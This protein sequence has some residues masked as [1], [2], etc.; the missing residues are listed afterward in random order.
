[1][2]SAIYFPTHQS[3]FGEMI[4]TGHLSPVAR[5]RIRPTFN[6]TRPGADDDDPVEYH[7]A[8]LAHKFAKI[9]G[10]SFPLF[11]DFPRYAPD[12]KVRD[13]TSSG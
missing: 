12:Y 2:H 5:T 7:L 11:F 1:M 3:K 4:G 13:G 8:D 10:T 9:W 6:I